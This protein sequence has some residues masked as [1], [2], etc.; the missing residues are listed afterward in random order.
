MTVAAYQGLYESSVAYGMRKA[1]RSE[2]LK[3]ELNKRTKEVEMQKLDLTHRVEELK[4]FCEE[5]AK[6]FA[7]NQTALEKKNSDELQQLKKINAAL[8]AELEEYLTV[9][10]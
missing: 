1:L 5:T 10:K 6:G 2:Q 8:K 3:A 7:D 4:Q 9:K